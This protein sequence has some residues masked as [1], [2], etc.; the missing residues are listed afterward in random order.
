MCGGSSFLDEQ[1]VLCVARVDWVQSLVLLNCI[2]FR[3]VQGGEF[4]FPFLLT[5]L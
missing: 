3:R 2:I 5:R 1:R 4:C